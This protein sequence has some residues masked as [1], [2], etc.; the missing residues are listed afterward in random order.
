M[1]FNAIIS[2]LVHKGVLVYEEGEALAKELQS[3]IVDTK[4]SAA[5]KDMTA[6]LYLIEK[7]ITP[8]IAPKKPIASNTKP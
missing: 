8:K 4:F 7:Q 3:S 5:H 1:N 2:L 6:V